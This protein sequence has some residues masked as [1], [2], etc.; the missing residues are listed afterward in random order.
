MEKS[1]IVCPY[2][3]VGCR[4]YI[5]KTPEGY[6]L[7]YADDIPGIPNENGSLCPKGNAVLDLL[8]KDRLKKPLKAK[9]EGK[10]VEISWSDAIKEAAE[11]LREI[12]RD[13]PNQLM[14][15]GSAKTYNEPNY[16]IQKLARMLGTNNIDHCARLCHSSTVAGLKAVFGAGAMTNTYRDIETADVI[17]MWGHNYAETHPVGFRYVLKAKER[18]AKVIVVDPRYTRT[19]WF[20][21]M[22]L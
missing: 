14:F 12:A 6:R 1:L 22:F 19:A 11:R 17:V 7:D 4:L 8:S 21:D 2:C 3:G 18:G 15:F 13:D 9:E 5:E 10:F 16:L 20:S